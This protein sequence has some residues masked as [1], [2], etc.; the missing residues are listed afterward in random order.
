M[1]LGMFQLFQQPDDGRGFQLSE[2]REHLVRKAGNLLPLP[3]LPGRLQTP[4]M[5]AGGRDERIQDTP[6][7]LLVM[8]R[9]RPDMLQRISLPLDRKSVV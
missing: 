5:L 7:R 4:D 1:I 8:V 9:K 3:L 6:Q 2:Q